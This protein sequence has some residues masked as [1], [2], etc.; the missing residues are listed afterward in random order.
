MRLERADDYRRWRSRAQTGKRV[1][2]L[3][4]WRIDSALLS[5][6]GRDGWQ[7]RPS[8]SGRQAGGD[9][10]RRQHRAAVGGGYV[11]RSCGHC[12]GTREVVCRA[13]F[14]PDGKLVVTA[15]DDHT[16]R[17]WE[18]ASGQVLRV[19]P[20]HQGAVW[21]AAFSPDGKLVVTASGDKTARL[22]DVA[23]GQMLRVLSGH[24]DGVWHA[25]FSPDGKLVVTA[26][27]D[28]TA[29]LWDVASGQ[30]LRELSGHQTG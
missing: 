9:C 23:S 5:E 4:R 26:S 11:G 17:L 25:A 14:S 7:P 16:A 29:R 22:W 19:L 13:A 27:G 8:W 10:Q 21:H 20:G 28:K 2:E 12:Q 30:V 24:Q 15:S 3:H 1:G 18:V 6:A